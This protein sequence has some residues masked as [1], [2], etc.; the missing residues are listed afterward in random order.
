MASIKRG[1]P[2][3]ELA[4]AI[5][6]SGVKEN[7]KRFLESDWYDNLSE[8]VR[9]DAKRVNNVNLRAVCKTKV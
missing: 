8:L 3:A 6:Q 4:A 1:D 5:I 9:L 7:D 2:W